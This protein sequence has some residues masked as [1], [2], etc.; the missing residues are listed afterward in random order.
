VISRISGVVALAA[1]VGLILWI[2]NATP[3]KLY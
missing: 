3:G 2:L 1:G